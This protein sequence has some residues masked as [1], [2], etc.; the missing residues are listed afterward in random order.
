MNMADKKAVTTTNTE[1]MPDKPGEKIILRAA[2]V[3]NMAPV[4]L[5]IS[6]AM[7]ITTLIFYIVQRLP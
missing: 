2:N 1:P 6:V 4:M 5:I 3:I 7:M